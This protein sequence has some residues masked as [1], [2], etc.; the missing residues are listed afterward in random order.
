MPRPGFVPGRSTRAHSFTMPLLLLLV[1]A[2]L[3]SAPAARPAPAPAPER[4]TTRVVEVRL[5]ARTPA[6]DGEVSEDEY[7]APTMLLPTAAGE[8]KVWVTRSGESVH[9]AA[10]LPDSTF[11]WGDDFVVSVDPNGDAGAAPGAGDRQ[12]YLRR[13]LDSSSVLTAPANGRWHAP[14]QPPPMLGSVR[15]GAD[16]RVAARSEAARWTVELR[17][18]AAAFGLSATEGAGNPSRPAPRLALRTYNDAPHGWWSWPAP[19]AGVPPVRVERNPEL[20]AE[21]HIAR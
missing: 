11:Y 9:I 15:S 17:V 10:I 20:W 18:D 4:D 8:A 16:W 5:L 3:H 2:A 6:M 1:L 19:P 12:W 7:G 21:V 14:D 13:S